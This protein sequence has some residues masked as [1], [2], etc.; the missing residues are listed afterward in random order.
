MTVFGFSL[1]TLTLPHSS[2]VIITIVFSVTVRN[3]TELNSYLLF[4]D[5]LFIRNDNLFPFAV[6]KSANFPLVYAP[7]TKLPS[8]ETS[9]ALTAQSFK[10]SS[11]NGFFSFWELRLKTLINP[12][13]FPTKS[14][15]VLL[16]RCTHMHVSWPK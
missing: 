15:L 4:L 14:I 11:L 12:F 3:L 1:I 5:M 6:S 16:Y 9:M 8:S 13:E 10:L 7:T 2:P